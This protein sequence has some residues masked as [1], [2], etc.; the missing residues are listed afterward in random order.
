VSEPI[1]VLS[2]GAG[3]QSSCM[4]LMAARGEITPMPQ[5]AIFADTGGEP[6]GV[7]DWLDWLEGELPYPVHKI[8]EKEGLTRHVNEG[9]ERKE[10]IGVPFYND[11]DGK[12]GVGRRQCTREYKVTPIARKMRELVGLKPRQHG[13]KEP[14]AILSIGISLDEIQRMKDSRDKW[15]QHRWPLIEKRIKRHECLQWMEDNGYPKPPRS[16]CWYCPF[17]S[18]EEWRRMKMDEPEYFQKAVDMDNRI[19]ATGRDGSEVFM[20][21]S[22]Q[23]LDEVDLSTDV[24]RGQTTLWDEECEGMCGI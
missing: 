20:H 2:L 13:G 18:N 14:L 22:R 11:L 5:A 24:E 4:A 1:H 9:I 16:A 8:M 7:Y 3:V 19:R 23:P 10:F 21:P 12:K 17:H 6:Q 15:Y